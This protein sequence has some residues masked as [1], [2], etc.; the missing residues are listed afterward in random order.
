MILVILT[1]P[2]WRVTIWQDEREDKGMMLRIGCQEHP[3]ER[4][5]GFS[6]ALITKMDTRALAWW[7]AYGAAV[8]AMADALNALENA[9]KAG[10]VK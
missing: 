7:K 4:W 1:L 5:R 10:G 8:L 3:V 9:R 2:N 6:D